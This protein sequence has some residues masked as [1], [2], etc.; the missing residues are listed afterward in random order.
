MKVCRGKDNCTSCTSF[1]NVAY[2]VKTN[3][4]CPEDTIGDTIQLG[5]KNGSDFE[6]MGICE[7][8]VFGQG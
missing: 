2:Y 8:E 6:Y 1:Q 3:S 5:I 7:L 4:T